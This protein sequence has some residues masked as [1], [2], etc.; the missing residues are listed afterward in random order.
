MESSAGLLSTIANTNTLVH[1]KL[2]KEDFNYFFGSLKKIEAKRNNPDIVFG[3]NGYD[4]FNA[5]VKNDKKE[6]KLIQ[7]RINKDHIKYIYTKSKQHNIDYDLLFLL[8]KS[9]KNTY[10]GGKLEFT[11]N[12]INYYTSEYDDSYE[13]ETINFKDGTWFY[14]K[15]WSDGYYKNKTL[16]N[17]ELTEKELLD[18]IIKY[19]K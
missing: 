11:I 4:Y 3:K 18:L 1:R 8:D 7:E 17:K 12:S 5:C 16:E 19:G 13:E 9:F 14:N 10:Y 15:V 2:T 6:M